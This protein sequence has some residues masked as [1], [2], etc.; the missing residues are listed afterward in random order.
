MSEVVHLTVEAVKA[1]HARVLERHGGLAGL[2]DEG[3]L[4]SAVSATQA[5][6][7]G[8]PLFAESG[9]V[10]AAYLFYICR[11]HPFNDGN[12]RTALVACL[13]VLEANGLLQDA[14]RPMRD[15][16]AWEEFVLD[17]AAGK[18]DRDETAKRLCGLLGGK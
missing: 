10:A 1:I 15:V 6:W 5:T 2:R 18:I 11:N 9:E 12:K 16:D 14:A 8:Q 4:Q 17:V 7:D 13:V 3:L